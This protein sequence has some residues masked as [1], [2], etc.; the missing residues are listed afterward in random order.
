[1]KVLALCASPRR[2]GNSQALAAAVVAGAVESGHTAELL[3]LCDFVEGMLRDCRSCRLPDGAC[4]IGDRY[5]ELI[6]AHVLPADGL[7]FATPL[8]WYGM[9][10]RLKTFFDRLFCLTSDSAVAGAEVSARITGK[11]VGAVISCEENYRG[12]SLGL[13]A[14]FQE[15]TRYL[16]QELVGVVVG[17]GNSRGEVANDPRGPLAAATLLG[18]QLFDL[19]LTDYRLDTPRANR[20]WPTPSAHNV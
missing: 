13:E 2:D 19:R 8:Y 12:A 15:L 16:R 20:V 4:G 11:R 9:S 14:Q 7:I 5:D 6:M 18:R 1:M 17:V 10:G 3:Y